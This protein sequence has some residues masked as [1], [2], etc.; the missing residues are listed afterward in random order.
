MCRK[1]K[2][3]VCERRLLIPNLIG[4]LW[5]TFAAW[6]PM[7]KTHINLHTHL[8]HRYNNNAPPLLKSCMLMLF[9]SDTAFGRNTHIDWW[10]IKHIICSFPV[11]GRW[12]GQV[13]SQRRTQ[14]PAFHLNQRKKWD[15]SVT[16]SNSTQPGPQA[17]G[18]TLTASICCRAEPQK[19]TTGNMRG[20]KVRMHSWQIG[21]HGW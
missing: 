6:S 1:W 3:A 16:E 2:E 11:S 10:L 9:F 17:S 8:I 13:Y 5:T 12:H 7:I 18:L 19:M 4:C 15:L 21:R 14:E 20:P